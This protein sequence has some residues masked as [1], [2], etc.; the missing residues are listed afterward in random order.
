MAIRITNPEDEFDHIFMIEQHNIQSRISHVSESPKYWVSVAYNRYKI[1][2]DG[3]IE[4]T[5]QSESLDVEDFYS[6]AVLNAQSGNMD[7][8]TAMLADQDAVAKMIADQ[9]SYAVEVI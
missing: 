8:L 9:T 1:N 4:Y 3:S 7:L 5:A 6:S 2:P